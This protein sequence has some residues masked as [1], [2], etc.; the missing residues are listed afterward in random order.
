MNKVITVHNTFS[1]KGIYKFFFW[2]T[3]IE[4][5]KSSFKFVFIKH[6]FLVGVSTSGMIAIN[7]FTIFKARTVFGFYE[8]KDQIVL[9]S[10]VLR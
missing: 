1:L 2:L 9:A 6:T 3:K 4:I 8:K 10:K 5:K 7:G